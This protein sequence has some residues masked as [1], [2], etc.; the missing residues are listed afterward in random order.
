MIE[1]FD[2]ADAR[3]VRNKDNLLAFYQR[4]I[5][6]KQPL[7]AARDLIAE[8]YI[9]HNPQLPDGAAGLGMAFNAIAQTRANARVVVHRIIASGD[10]VWA[11]VNFLGLYNDDVD[12]LGVAGVD[13]WK[14]DADGVAV[15]HWDVLQPVA[16]AVSPVNGHGMF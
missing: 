2:P 11:H 5:D 9:Q 12:D 13:I 14:M 8:D 6:E 4:A 16:A 3:A 10:W 7:E 1:I 15:E